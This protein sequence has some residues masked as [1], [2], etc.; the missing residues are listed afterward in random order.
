MA[1]QLPERSALDPRPAPAGAALPAAVRPGGDAPRDR[2]G[3]VRGDTPRVAGVREAVGGH[4]G[5][6]LLRGR[7]ARRGGE[8]GGR[9]GGG[10]ETLAT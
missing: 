4:G 8:R 5:L 6:G 3:H 2:A 7:G 9:E 10:G 1:S